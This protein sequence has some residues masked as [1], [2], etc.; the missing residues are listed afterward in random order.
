MET[1]AHYPAR[2]I[3][4]WFQDEGR[5]GQKGRVAHRW[6]R[7]GERPLGLCD[8]RFS[9]TYIYATVCPET[10]ESFALVMPKV[11]TVS[12]NT[13]LEEFSKSL[14]PNVLALLIMD[15]AGWHGARK[16]TMPENI[17]PVPLPSYSPELN[18][19]ERVWL[20]LRERFMSHRLFNDYN[21]IVEACSKAW[22]AL[23][24]DTERLRSLTSYPWL[25][26]VNH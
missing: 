1:T 21:D 15:R 22:N 14:E 26:C 18:P 10:G 24:A 11:N 17:I 12:M 7:R 23:A 5:F 16:L 8:R 6:W 19:V 3:Q 13:F 9:S 25:P 4:I 2:R 20:Y